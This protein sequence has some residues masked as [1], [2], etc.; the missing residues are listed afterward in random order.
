[1]HN[2]SRRK[3]GVFL[4]VVEAGSFTKGARISNISEPATISIINELE[5]TLDAELFE[6]AG[7]IRTGKLTPRGQEV[8]QILSKALAVYDQTLGALSSPKKRRTPKVLIQ[9]PYAPAVLWYWLGS[10]IAKFK[11]HQINISSAERGEIFQAIEKRDECIGFIDGNARPR[12]SEYIPLCTSEIVLV[13]SDSAAKDFNFN[14]ERISWHDVPESTILYC[15][16]APNT[17]K[18]IYENL[19]ENGARKGELTEVNC[20]DILR[21]FIFEL[22]VPALLPEIMARYLRNDTDLR[23]LRFSFSPVHVPLGLVVPYGQ[24]LQF[25]FNRSDVQKAFSLAR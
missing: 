21:H 16:I 23:L 4:S 22:G 24:T 19:R 9:T 14:T 12:N 1:M 8:Y 10:L 20:A 15:G 13:Y 18:K 3:L 25:K 5:S 6:R 7:K 17:T 2:L 11:E